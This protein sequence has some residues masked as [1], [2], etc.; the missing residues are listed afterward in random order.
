MVEIGEEKDCSQRACSLSFGELH[1]WS[2]KKWFC[3]KFV[4]CSVFKKRFKFCNLKQDAQC[5]RQRE[6]EA[7]YNLLQVENYSKDSRRSVLLKAKVSGHCHLYMRK[8]GDE[9][10]HKT[11]IIITVF[12]R[13]HW[14]PGHQHEITE[15]DRALFSHIMNFCRVGDATAPLVTHHTSREFSPPVARSDSICCATLPQAVVG[16]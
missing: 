12:G 8:W 13:S 5:Y 15:S 9:L 2:Y 1:I 3:C 4:G 10:A 14:L 11:E 7:G 6:L 16:C